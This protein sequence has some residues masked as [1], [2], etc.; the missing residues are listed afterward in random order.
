[1][2]QVFHLDLEKVVSLIKNKKEINSNNLDILKPTKFFVLDHG[3]YYMS[4]LA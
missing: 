4:Y 1:L 2:I 3:L